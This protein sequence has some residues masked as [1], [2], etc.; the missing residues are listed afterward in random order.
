MKLT[1]I[2]GQMRPYQL[3][4]LNWMV[5]LH[6]NGLNGILADEMGLG[7]TLQTISFLTY[8]KYRQNIPGPH[9]VVVPKSTLQNWAREFEHWSPTFNV[10]VLTGSKDERAALIQDRLMTQD[11]EVIVTS[12]EICLIEKTALKKFSFEYI[13]IDEAHRIKNVDSMLSQIVRAFTSRGRLLITGTPLQNNL[14]ELFA[15]LNFICPEIFVDY[16]DL[17]AFLHKDDTANLEGK[18]G[19]EAPGDQDKSKKV[20]EALHKILRPFLLRR[21]KADVEK[22]LLPS[23]SPKLDSKIAADIL[24]YS[25]KEINIYVGLTEMQ[26]KWYRSVLEKD[27]DAVNGMLKYS[28][29]GIWRSNHC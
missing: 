13:V 10:I 21:V 25:E 7:K 14:K 26:R 2:N 18:E 28:L 6:H 16:A 11:F 12:Y 20:V 3:Q 22:S 5:S 24:S 27:I 29:H 1:V 9:L 15:L 17:D 23:T 8:L 19:E 4:G